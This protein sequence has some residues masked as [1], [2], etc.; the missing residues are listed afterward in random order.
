M[1]ITDHSPSVHEIARPEPF[2]GITIDSTSPTYF[3]VGEH[4]YSYMG[5]DV[6]LVGRTSGLTAGEV[7]G[8]CVHY[9]DPDDSSRILVCQDT[10]TYESDSGDSGAPVFSIQGGTSVLM[11]GIHWARVGF[12][13]PG[14]YIRRSFSPMSQVRIDLDMLEPLFHW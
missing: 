10:G 6:F 11:A 13:F 7:D 14:G 5:M 9:Q 1:S 4:P 8:T 12:V 3:V 2:G